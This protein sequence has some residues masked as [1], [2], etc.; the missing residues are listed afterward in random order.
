MKIKG[1]RSI[2]QYTSVGLF[3]FTTMGIQWNLRLGPPFLNDQLFKIPKVSPSN[4]YTWNL[5]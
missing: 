5:L 1:R 4:Q 3:D 2:D